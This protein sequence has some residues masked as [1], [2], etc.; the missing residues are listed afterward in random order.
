MPQVLTLSPDLPEPPATSPRA[1]P[2]VF[3]PRPPRAN[4]PQPGQGGG[5]AMLVSAAPQPEGPSTTG[6]TGVYQSTVTDI[7]LFSP[8]PAPARVVASSG[9]CGR[10]GLETT[11]PKKAAFPPQKK[12][13]ARASGGVGAPGGPVRPCVPAGPPPAPLSPA[14]RPPAAGGCGEAAAGSGRTGKSNKTVSSLLS[15][16]SLFF[17]FFFLGPNI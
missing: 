1:E 11:A 2:E 7:K 12:E 17:F 15:V 9:R 8:R 10:A 16:P 5:G 14:E 6:G 13:V 4:G 3:H